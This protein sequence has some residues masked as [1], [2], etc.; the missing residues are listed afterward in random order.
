MRALLKTY[1][2]YMEA[3]L[4]VEKLAEAGISAVAL[5]LTGPAADGPNLSSALWLEDDSLLEDEATREIIEETLAESEFT[6]EEEEWIASLP[7]ED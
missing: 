3:Q 2:S 4:L 1:P 5:R 6:P 7:P